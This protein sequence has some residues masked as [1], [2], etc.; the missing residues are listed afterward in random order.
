MTV[1]RLCFG[2][3][4]VV[5]LV[6]SI[7]WVEVAPAEGE[8]TSTADSAIAA[9]FGV[10]GTWSFFGFLVTGLISAKPRS[11]WAVRTQRIAENAG[12]YLL[13]VLGFLAMI[14][15]TGS[16]YPLVG[17]AFVV[18][19]PASFALFY[20]VHRTRASGLARLSLGQYLRRFLNGIRT[21]ALVIVLPMAVLTGV[22][23]LTR[24]LGLDAFALSFMVFQF[25]VL[26][27]LFILLALATL[28]GISAKLVERRDDRDAWAT[29]PL[30]AVIPWKPLDSVDYQELWERTGLSG[31]ATAKAA[32]SIP[33]EPI[34][35]FEAVLPSGERLQVL[36]TTRE[37]IT[38]PQPTWA[39]GLFILGVRD[40][41]EGRQTRRIHVFARL[42]CRW[43]LLQADI[44][45]EEIR[46]WDSEISME[47]LASFRCRDCRLMRTD[48]RGAED[49]VL[50]VVRNPDGP[51]EVA[52]MLGAFLLY[53]RSDYP[54]SAVASPAAA[55]A[56]S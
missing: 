38:T 19:V 8:P 2:L 25:A 7:A 21:A 33:N 15:L 28:I 20:T 43:E 40:G 31:A 24:N 3:A 16:D 18:C 30:Y 50:S 52:Y 11:A 56:S 26:Y 41:P 5:P 4:L 44:A 23:F 32:W 51:S 42:G 47:R 53:S 37:R 29:F 1:S 36:E 48:F 54:K 39:A 34:R 14:A 27:G 45:A 55:A 46:H 9:L 6:A 49:R 22:V 12:A 35:R 17:L 10:V 13:A